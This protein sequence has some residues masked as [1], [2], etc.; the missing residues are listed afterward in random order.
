M[1]FAPDIGM[2]GYLINTR[3]GAWTYNLLHLLAIGIGLYVVGY[4]F[5]NAFVELAGIMIIG[6]I[7]LDRLLGYGLKHEDSFKHTHLGTI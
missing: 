1:L 5:N 2:V 7:A 3:V 4:F 6:H